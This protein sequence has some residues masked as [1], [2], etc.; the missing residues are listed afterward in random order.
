[1]SAIR[2]KTETEVP[3]WGAAYIVALIA[4]AVRGTARSPRGIGLNTDEAARIADE[5]LEQLRKREAKP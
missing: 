3:L 2:F 5:T 1:M 4:E